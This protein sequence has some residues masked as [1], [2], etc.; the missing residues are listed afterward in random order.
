[1]DRNE[2]EYDEVYDE[3]VADKILSIYE[4]NK[5]NDYLNDE[6]VTSILMD[7]TRI[8]AN[9]NLSVQTAIRK[10]AQI[11]ALSFAFKLQAKNYM[12]IEKGDP[13]AQQKKNLYATLAEQCELLAQALKYSTR[14]Y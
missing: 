6:N 4:L 5:I 12:L 11:Q 7:V 3:N 13:K 1:M 2:T 8:I 14:N 9:P 10:I